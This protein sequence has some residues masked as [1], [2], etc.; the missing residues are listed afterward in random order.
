MGISLLL[1]FGQLFHGQGSI[2]QIS[3]AHITFCISYV[4]VVV[5]ARAANL[6]PA[7]GGGGARPRVVGVGRVPLT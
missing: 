5:R 1:F 7:A 2:Q 3:I 4:A 6:D